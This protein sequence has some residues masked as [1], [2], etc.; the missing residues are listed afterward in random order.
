MDH[1]ALRKQLAS[2][3]HNTRLAARESLSGHVDCW[4]ALN[5][6]IFEP[7]SLPTRIIR[8]YLCRGGEY[9]GIVEAVTEEEETLRSDFIEVNIIDPIGSGSPKPGEVSLFSIGNQFILQ[10]W[11]GKQDLSQHVFIGSYRGRWI[12]FVEENYGKDKNKKKK[13]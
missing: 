10:R 7:I 6:A 12:S 1:L 11:D 2:E 9:F 5:K 13:N 8:T 4:E 3:Y